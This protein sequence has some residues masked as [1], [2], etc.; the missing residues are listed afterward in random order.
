MNQLG[1]LS[2]ILDDFDEI[3]LLKSK[4]KGIEKEMLDKKFPIVVFG[5]KE[6]PY[7]KI[8]ISFLADT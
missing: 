2:R 1:A 6:L 5:N 8:S 3:F 7:L 4:K